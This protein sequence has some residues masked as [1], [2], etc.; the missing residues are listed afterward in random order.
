MNA[1]LAD[2]LSQP[3]AL[4]TALDGFRPAALDDVAR[5]LQSGA[6]ERVVITGMGS[7]YFAA[8]P[9]WLRLVEAGVPV[10]HVEASELL[11]NAS[12]LVTGKT[13]LC[14]IS[15]SGR[16]AEILALLE[17]VR[18]GHLLAITNDD[19][20]PLAARARTVLNMHAG[21]ETNVST[22]TYLNTLAVVQL[23]AERLAGA[24][25]DKVRGDLQEAVHALRGFLVNWQDVVA[26]WAK[27]VGRAER[28]FYLGRGASLAAVWT[29]ALTTKESAKFTVEGMSAGQFRH[30]PLELA[31]D[32]LA[33]VI[34]AGASGTRELN[35]RLAG[36]LVGYGVKVTWLGADPLGG[37][38]SIV[39][40]SV[41]GA[42]R[43]IAEMAPLQ[44]LTLHLAQVSG[45]EAGQFRHSGKVT[46]SE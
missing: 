11:H 34:L 8:Y 18:P 30:G 10:W 17:R 44:L 28:L 14:M 42:G 6:F 29:A 16:S 45:V 13:L 23:A 19:S 46:A 20:S 35:R 40:P 26:A 7:S 39:H 12:H 5:Q 37:L 3:N 41:R 4:Q 15:Q 9:A 38:A 33:V 1:Y 36:D 43:P 22:K 2:I 25:V 27:A 32:R 21:V 24:P 31:D